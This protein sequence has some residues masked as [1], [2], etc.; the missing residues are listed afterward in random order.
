M[1]MGEEYAERIKCL[2][3]PVSKQFFNVNRKTLRL[4][5]E[6]EFY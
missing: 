1:D 5:G 6:A 3:D 2:C 4:H